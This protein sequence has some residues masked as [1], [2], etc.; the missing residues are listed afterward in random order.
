VGDYGNVL[1]VQQTGGS[2]QW[3]A[4]DAGGVISFQFGTPV[5]EVV[6]L[7]FSMLS[8]KYGFR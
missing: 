3:K 7:G 4:N 6:E 2:S 8:R 5:D 1:I